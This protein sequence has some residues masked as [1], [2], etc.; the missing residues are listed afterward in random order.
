MITAV[1][2]DMVTENII[3]MAQDQLKAL[4]QTDA[5]CLENSEA[6]HY[7][8]KALAAL[9]YRKDKL[10]VKEAATIGTSES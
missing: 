4:Q 1:E 8:E 10:K 6:L 2:A 7:L 3:C 5:R 9:R